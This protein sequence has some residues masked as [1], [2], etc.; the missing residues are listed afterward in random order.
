M[1][2][3]ITISASESEEGYTTPGQSMRK[4]FFINV[5][6]CHTYTLIRYA[7]TPYLCFTRNGSH[8]AHILLL[9]CIDNT[10]LSNIW[11]TYK[12]N[13]DLLLI[14]VEESELSQQIKQRTLT[15]RVLYR[16]MERQCR[17][18]NEYCGRE[19]EAYS[20]ERMAT[21]F[22]VAQVGMRSH[23]FR[24]KIICLCRACFF[25]CCSTR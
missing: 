25:K 17:I 14:L 7:N 6:Y 4:I 9:Q 21:H 24:M 8:F 19:E 12:S 20:W 15:V 18:P 2:T 23:L 3:L 13:T 22:F 11:I 16:R 1:N 5:M 10:T